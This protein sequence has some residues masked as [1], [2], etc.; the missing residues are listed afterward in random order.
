MKS[1]LALLPMILASVVVAGSQTIAGETAGKYGRVDYLLHCS[2]CHGTKGNGT[3][4][5]GIPAFPNSISHIA[6]YENGR[7]Y[8]LQVPGVIT[9]NMSDPEIARVLNYILEEWGD[10]AEVAPF[11][12]PEVTRRRALPAREVAEYRREIT[13]EL[14]QS[15]IEIAEYPWP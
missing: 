12:G 4:T 10:G 6:S 2:G 14:R 13:E 3:I 5:G 11:S 8:I 7:N 1:R 9:T 15:D